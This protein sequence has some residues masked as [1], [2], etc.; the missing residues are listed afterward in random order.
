MKA[1]LTL[2]FTLILASSFAQDTSRKYYFK[3]IGWAIE[4]PQDFK[5]IDTKYAVN[6]GLIV[7]RGF[8]VASGVK[9][10]SNNSR[11]LI[12]ATMG[13]T[14]FFASIDSFKL[15]LDS[16]WAMVQQKLKEESYERIAKIAPT[17]KLDSGSTFVNIDGIAFDQFK[18]SATFNGMQYPNFV[19]LSK[20]YKGYYFTIT[21]MYDDEIVRQEIETMLKNSKFDK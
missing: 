12:C 16:W 3:E 14:F 13:E 4:L 2:G 18:V 9:T 15:T 17:W 10:D 19:R 11:I 21:Y 20:L 1:L 5:V 8:E 7:P 6:N